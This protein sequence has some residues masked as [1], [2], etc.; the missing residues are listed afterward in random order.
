MYNSK[1]DFAVNKNDPD[2]I[3]YISVT[4][5]RIR[6]ISS[7]FTSSEEFRH[8]KAWSDDDYK[9]IDRQGRW[10][11]DHTLSFIDTADSKSISAEDMWF[12]LRCN[13]K[14]KFFQGKLKDLMKANL[15]ETQYRR[16][17]MFY[18]E[19]QSM[20]NIALA[21]G[22]TEPSVSESVARAR[23][24]LTEIFKKYT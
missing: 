11:N 21:E 2:A 3:V 13:E 12:Y 15:T 14:R 1:S 23:K 16:L 22:I 7:D 9:D 4:G 5:E 18:A 20:K 8:W 10:F 6:L 19:K 17:W 24:K